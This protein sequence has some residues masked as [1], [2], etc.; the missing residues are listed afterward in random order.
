MVNLVTAEVLGRWLSSTVFLLAQNEN[1][2]SVVWGVAGPFASFA[3]TA[4]SMKKPLFASEQR[5][6][7]DTST[8]VGK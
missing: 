8:L 1:Q 3:W 4:K 2:R 7:F 6:L 5:F